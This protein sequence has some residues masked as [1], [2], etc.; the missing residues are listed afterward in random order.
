VSDQ[1]HIASFAIDE[2]GFSPR[3]LRAYYF[4]EGRDFPKDARLKE[5][6]VYDYELEFITF[7]EGSMVI[8]DR[9]YKVAKGDILFRRPGEY[10]Q[11]TMPYVCYYIGFD[12]LGNMDKDLDTYNFHNPQDF[13]PLY[14]N[15]ILDRL[16]TRFHPAEYEKYLFLF[17][18]VFHERVHPSTCSKIIIKATILQILS[19]LYADSAASKVE[20]RLASS[21]YKAVI[22]KVLSYID[23][24]YAKR[25]LLE[26]LAAIAG[27]SASHFHKVFSGVIGTT[28]NHY[29]LSK[30]LKH[31]KTLLSKQ[32]T[33][34]TEVALQSGFDSAAYFS[35]SFK[36]HVGIS[37][38]NFR[39]QFCHIP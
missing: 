18:K 1:E 11:A 33:G 9:D 32:R 28:P 27:L 8:G 36:K 23:E 39:E 35:Y 2:D 10:T 29:I 21:P 15:P 20:D 25:I 5:R 6:Y 16:P 19:E 24:N 7:S 14:R 17:E 22:T 30:R 3:L 4:A 13:Q 26:D 37:P 12:L 38:R 31:A 34:I